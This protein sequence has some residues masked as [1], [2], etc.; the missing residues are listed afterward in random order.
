MLYVRVFRG[1]L[2]RF[3]IGDDG[4]VVVAEAGQRMAFHPERACIGDAVD[5]CVCP[6]SRTAWLKSRRRMQSRMAALRR[7][8]A[9]R[10]QG[11][12]VGEDLQG[13]VGVAGLFERVGQALSGYRRR[14]GRR[15][16]L[17]ARQA[18]AS[19]MRPRSSIV[20]PRMA[21]AS[22]SAGSLMTASAAS[23]A[24]PS[25]SPSRRRQFRPAIA[26]PGMGRRGVDAGVQLQQCLVPCAACPWR[27]GRR[28]G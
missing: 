22:G 6:A 27:C 17:R 15:S 19:A 20:D 12:A 24:A 18:I 3:L 5:A 4:L 28:S 7:A 9:L 8:S 14:W 1:E 16:S 26:Q 25:W 10:D 21:L 2:E 11:D 23:R 13:G